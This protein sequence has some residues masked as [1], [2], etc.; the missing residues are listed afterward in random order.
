ME[1]SSIYT[2]WWLTCV[3]YPT[4]GG[5]GRSSRSTST[6]REF[7]ATLGYWPGTGTVTLFPRALGGLCTDSLFLI[8]PDCKGLVRIFSLSLLTCYLWTQETAVLCLPLTVSSAWASLRLKFALPANTL[9]LSHRHPKITWNGGLK[10]LLMSFQSIKCWFPSNA[11]MPALSSH[12]W[13]LCC[14]KCSCLF[15][16]TR[17]GWNCFD[18][19]TINRWLFLRGRSS[20]PLFT[21]FP[22]GQNPQVCTNVQF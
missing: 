7:E 9:F 4:L 21:C 13:N 16:L 5:G 18:L 2:V 11:Q 10:R 6:H 14:S 12:R 15:K 1:W 8:T 20:S 17:P 19:A 22:S 3:C